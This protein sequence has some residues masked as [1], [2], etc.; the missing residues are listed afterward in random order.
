[1]WYNTK[2]FYTILHKFCNL[3]CKNASVM[4]YHKYYTNRY[5]SFFFSRQ[6]S[7]RLSSSDHSHSIILREWVDSCRDAILQFIQSRVITKTLSFAYQQREKSQT[8]RSDDLRGHLQNIWSIHLLEDVFQR[9]DN[10]M[11]V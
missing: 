1:M 9:P 4:Y 3:N 10:K 7:M 6:I 8:V 11:S 2:L 5:A